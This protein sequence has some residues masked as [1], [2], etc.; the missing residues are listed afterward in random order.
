MKKA[1]KEAEMALKEERKAN[2]T[3]VLVTANS[4]TNGA[5]VAPAAVPVA[6]VALNAAKNAGILAA[7]IIGSFDESVSIKLATFKKEMEA[8]VMLKVKNLQQKGLQNN[9]D[10]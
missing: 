4:T 2:A 1:L 5:R 7:Q 10:N 9:F 6:T 3:M 8:E